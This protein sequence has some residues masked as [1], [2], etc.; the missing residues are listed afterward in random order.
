MSRTFLAGA[1]AGM[2]LAGLAASL[3]VGDSAAAPFNAV[4]TKRADA[5]VVTS[6]CI[7]LSDSSFVAAM[8]VPESRQL[9]DGGTRVV[10]NSLQSQRCTLTAGQRTTA[11][12]FANGPAATCVRLSHDLE[13]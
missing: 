8:D 9:P 10:V 1:V 4:V 13:Q 12:N 6:F 3:V 5:G 7:T 11:E 2:A